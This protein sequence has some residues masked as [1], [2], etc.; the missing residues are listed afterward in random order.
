[1]SSTLAINSDFVTLNSSVLSMGGE[2]VD[3]AAY[4][5]ILKSMGTVEDLGEMV[6]ISASTA[7]F[8]NIMSFTAWAKVTT[9]GSW[10]YWAFLS[11]EDSDNNDSN[12][13]SLSYTDMGTGDKLRGYALNDLSQPRQNQLVT[14]TS[15]DAG[16]HHWVMTWDGS[17]DTMKYYQDG[18][19]LNVATDYAS[20]DATPPIDNATRLVRLGRAQGLPNMV[21]TLY[22][23]A[24]YDVAL[25]Q[26][27]ITALYNGGD[28]SAF[29]VMTD[30]G[31]YNTSS[32]CRSMYQLGNGTVHTD[33]GQDR[34]QD[35]SR[36][37][38]GAGWTVD[39]LVDDYPGMP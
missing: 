10:N 11:I 15:A 23:L 39:N 24:F 4:V 25:D 27:N 34:G 16:W 5:P 31:N 18:A 30:S 38:S 2:T 29:D 12:L 9:W 28:G 1:M 32:N 6:Q 35:A 14:T 36:H 33:Y 8:T 19:L 37:C 22:S 17:A 3:R 21:G 7:G 13:F 20:S 26:N